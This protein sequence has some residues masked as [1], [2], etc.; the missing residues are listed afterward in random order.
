MYKIAI[1]EL[2][3]FL[4]DIY[5]SVES[6]DKNSLLQQKLISKAP[7]SYFIVAQR[8]SDV[9]CF[10]IGDIEGFKNSNIVYTILD[11]NDLSGF[12]EMNRGQYIDKKWLRAYEVENIIIDNF[13][14]N[15]ES[16][17]RMARAILV[18]E[19]SDFISWKLADNT[20][21]NVSKLELATALRL[22]GELQT[23]IW[24]KYA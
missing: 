23:Q 7:Y 2:V 4:K 13:Q 15:E 6:A 1:S 17:T 10:I 16:Q 24:V 18:M 14:G 12:R 8:D 5:E 20:F 11:L 9:I 22:A 21:A 19:D 3:K